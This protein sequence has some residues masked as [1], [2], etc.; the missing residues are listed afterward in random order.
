MFV[1]RDFM[2][3]PSEKDSFSRNLPPNVLASEDIIPSGQYVVEGLLAPSIQASSQK[4]FRQSY[5]LDKMCSRIVRTIPAAWDHPNSI[6]CRIFLDDVE[7]TSDGFEQTHCLLSSGI[8]V[9]GQLR[10]KI[11]IYNLAETS[12]MD[13]PP[14]S[15]E[16]CSLIELF[17][18]SLAKAICLE[19]I[20]DEADRLAGLPGGNPNPIL[21]AANSGKILYAN[22]A[23]NE[24]LESN[25]EAWFEDVHSTWLANIGKSLHTGCPLEVEHSFKDRVFSFT[26]MPLPEKQYVNIYGKDISERKRAE[27]QFIQ[28]QKLEAMGLLAG[29]VAHDFRNQLTIIKGFG[30]MM[31]RRNI[32]PLEHADKVEIILKAVEN[33]TGLVTE[34]LALSHHEILEPRVVDLGD[35]TEMLGK[36]VVHIIGEDIQLTVKKLSQNCRTEIDPTLF[37]QAMIN[38][39]INARDAMPQGGNLQIETDMVKVETSQSDKLPSLA[40]GKYAAV[41]ISDSGI[42]MDSTVQERMFEPFFTTK[43]ETDGTG[44]GLTMVNGFVNKCNGHIE[45]ESFPDKGTKFS[46]FFPATDKPLPDELPEENISNHQ[47][48]NEHVLIVEDETPI[49]QMIEMAL[50]EAGYKVTAVGSP[51]QAIHLAQQKDTAFDLLVTDVVMPEMTGTQLAEQIESNIAKARVLFLSGYTPDELSRRGALAARRNMLT[52]PYTHQR[53]LKKVRETLDASGETQ[54]EDELVF[55]EK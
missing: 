45:C 34:L 31:L 14:C 25:G 40:P 37:N 27:N 21:R 33:S 50:I 2:E 1:K 20:V 54:T 11:E 28:S 39:I 24:L 41:T 38:L 15:E 5:S 3:Q 19:D 17:T 42:G 36:A 46:I 12:G 23:A 16:N 55:M 13:E 49:R 32:V 48:V 53:L 52:K 29:G 10:G 8:V 44:L 7:Y 6:H 4:T 30:E 18:N 26:F 9:N 22:K 47:V 51:K 43:N 35:L